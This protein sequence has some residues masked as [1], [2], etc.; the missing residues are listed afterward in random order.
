M[1]LMA[2]HDVKL[3]ALQRAVN[4]VRASKKEI[5]QINKIE[6]LRVQRMNAK[7]RERNYQYALALSLLLNILVI[8]WK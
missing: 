2:R 4:H 7:K 8:L 6:H 5:V 1:E 3:S